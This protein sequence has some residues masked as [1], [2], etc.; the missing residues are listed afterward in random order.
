MSLNKKSRLIIACISTIILV[1]FT[2][3]GYNFHKSAMRVEL[4]SRVLFVTQRISTLADKNPQLF[5]EILSGLNTNWTILSDKQYNR[6]ADAIISTESRYYAGDEEKMRYVFFDGNRRRY[7]IFARS[8]DA[9]TGKYELVVGTL[10]ITVDWVKN[11][12]V[13][14]LYD[15]IGKINIPAVRILIASP[16]NS[17]DGK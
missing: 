6:L 10:K 12:K 2:V 15:G 14:L 1:V 7:S 3:V 11:N 5:V 4:L 9:G 13:P 16:T 8:D 17:S